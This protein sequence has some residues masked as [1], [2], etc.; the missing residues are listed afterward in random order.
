VAQAQ[1][2]KDCREGS[3]MLGWLGSVVGIALVVLAAGSASAL[4]PAY[5]CNNPPTLDPAS[6]LFMAGDISEFPV[7]DA[8]D[9]FAWQDFVA[10]NW[11]VAP[12]WPGDPSKAGQPDRTAKASDWGSPAQGNSPAQAPTV[13]E[14]FM[15]VQLIF[16]PDGAAP[17]AW[18]VLGG[19]V[20][21][22]CGNALALAPQALAA[23]HVLTATSKF[24]P[25]TI[26]KNT[27]NA[28]ADA[29]GPDQTDQVV[30]GWLTDQAGK[31]VWYERRVNQVE[32]AY[33]TSNVLYQPD[34]QQN[35]AIQKGFTLPQGKQPGNEPQN[36][37][38][39]GSVEIKAA[40]R[41]L[42]G[43]KSLWPSYYVIEAVLID[44]DTKMCSQAVMGLV[45]LHIIHKTSSFP[46]F[47]W[48][49]FEHVDNAPDESGG[50]APT[51][52][53]SFNNPNC[54]GAD[55]EP[56]APR[57]V[58]DH[59]HCKDQF[60][61]TDPVQVVRK[62]P[63]SSDPRKGAV[64]QLNLAMQNAIR[65]ANPNSVFANYQLVNTLWVQSPGTDYTPPCATGP[66]NAANMTSASQNPVAN[67]TMETYV[68]TKTCTN[69]HNDATVA[70]GGTCPEN[71]KRLASDFSFIFS[72]AQ[73]PEQ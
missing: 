45:G 19:S 61:M 52:G 1:F 16:L 43:L 31:L 29:I 36:W 34:K 30:G 12:A 68:Q 54:A 37:S 69:C 22:S 70:G 32:Y 20:P 33:I 72:L 9:C 39:L 67:T 62:R 49:T 14:T 7:Q 40:W 2:R 26:P 59:G 44:P 60:P 15:P 55:C 48:A 6:P 21:P 3:V 17:P 57:K 4:T 58:C 18:G 51:N 27:L 66:L 24:F 46:N 53:W 11:P 38:D 35:L 65:S 10:L 47:L 23:P 50:P 56:N 28:L 73:G 63:I 13:W 8:V 5:N 41:N 42:T 71:G 64:A 25:R